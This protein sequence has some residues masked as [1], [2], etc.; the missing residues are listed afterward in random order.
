MNV[1]WRKTLSLVIVSVALSAAFGNGVE[2]EKT[3]LE[4][5]GFE[6][7]SLFQKTPLGW[8]KTV[9][10]KLKDHVEFIWDSEVAYKGKM[11]VSI[12]LSED[13]PRDIIAY[14]WNTDIQ[15]WEAGKHYELSCWVKGQD[16]KEPV[17]VCVQCW[18]EAMS[19]MIN[20]TT[21][22]RDY[23][24]TGTFDWQQIGAVFTVPEKTHKVV[25]RAGIA[26]PGNNGAQ[27]WFDELHIREVSETDQ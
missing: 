25:V 16:L 24:I 22:Q 7:L 20:F 14:N 10:P 6:S 8:R 27:A 11:S 19:K 1:F 21:T 15:N 13:H 12:R 23:P 17:W 4:S 26:A 5:S 9:V 3:F 2:K 18:D